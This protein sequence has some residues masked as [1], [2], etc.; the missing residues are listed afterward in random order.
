V[1][2]VAAQLVGACVT[3][4][5]ANVYAAVS[6][7]VSLRSVFYPCRQYHG[8]NRYRVQAHKFLR[9]MGGIK[10]GGLA[11]VCNLVSCFYAA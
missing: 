6:K 8:E 11:M 4:R 5:P 9:A 2:S 7:F 3:D 10:K 1:R